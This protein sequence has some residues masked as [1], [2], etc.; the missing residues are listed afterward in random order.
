[1]VEAEKRKTDALEA[2]NNM[3][4]KVELTENKW[5]GIYYPSY[6]QYLLHALLI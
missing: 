1:V 5:K 4:K 6:L 2:L 3:T